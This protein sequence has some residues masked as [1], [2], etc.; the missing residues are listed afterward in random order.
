MAARCERLKMAILTGPATVAISTVPNSEARAIPSAM[1]SPASIASFER[2]LNRLVAKFEKEFTSVTDPGYS[3]AR[4]R[5]D[6][7]DPLIHALGWDLQNHAGLVQHQREIEIESRTDIAGRAKRADYLFR[8]DGHDRFVCEAKKPRVV[9]GPRD[10]FQAKRYAYN[11]KVPLALLT[12][13]EDL[14]VF[15]VGGKPYMD[16]PDV[17]L[18]KSWHYKQYPLVAEEI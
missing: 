12:D 9:L 17:G 5:Q 15:L 4:L 14:K 2:E 1:S 16:S 7:L 8:T 18:W 10:A 11:K 3:Q 6:Y 13:F